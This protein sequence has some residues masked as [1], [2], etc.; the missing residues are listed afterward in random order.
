MSLPDLQRL[1]GRATPRWEDVRSPDRTDFIRREH[2]HLPFR[3][4]VDALDALQ[5]SVDTFVAQMRELPYTTL[6]KETA[7]HGLHRLLDGVTL[8]GA[9]AKCPPPAEPEPQEMSADVGDEPPSEEAME[10]AK[11]AG[12]DCFRNKDF[13]GAIK[14]YGSAIKLAPEGHE[15]L[16]ALHSNR[17]AA[18]LQAGFET[19][20]LADA[21]RCVELAP[22]WPKGY[23]RKGSCLRQLRRFDEARQ[24]FQRGAKL[25]PV[26]EDWARE[27]ERIDK[28]QRDSPEA[29]ARQLVLNLLPE[30]LRAWVRSVGVPEASPADKTVS[31]VLQLQVK[32]DLQDFGAPKWNLLQE[33][34]DQAKGQIRFT[35]LSREA[36]LANLAANMQSPVEGV[37]SHD[38]QGQ[39]LKIADVSSFLQSTK[40]SQQAA[41]HIDIMK[42]GRAVG[43]LFRIPCDASMAPYFSKH[44]DPP[45]PQVDVKPVLQL[46][47]SSGF[48]KTLPTYLGFQAFPGDL[49]FPVID[50]A[51]DASGA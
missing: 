32:G 14:H 36:Y 22:N 5:F 20:A 26:N 23:F 11:K 8:C 24:A 31:G 40:A 21:D 49:N 44:V 45:P 4:V 10:K 13:A 43:L 50:L 9:S 7:V 41:V 48:P 47:R 1:I 33:K 46:Q 27:T 42:D 51:R 25:E 30:I 16:A 28:A 39:A 3:E 17:S 18:L 19:A 35:F 34:K 29:M 12:G 6:E 15:S 37:G 38:I 2:S